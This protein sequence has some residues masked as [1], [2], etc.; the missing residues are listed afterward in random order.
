M[1]LKPE[2]FEELSALAERNPELAIQIQRLW[3]A[4]HR[5]GI[6]ASEL[7]RI[8]RNLRAVVRE[9]KSINARLDQ[10]KKGKP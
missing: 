1:N 6:K 9:L 5:P 3:S 10:M 7:L 8:S 2:S 4:M